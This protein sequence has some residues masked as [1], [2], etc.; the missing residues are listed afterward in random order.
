MVYTQLQLREVFHLEFLRWLGRKVKMNCYALKGGVNL[1]F[2]FH[3]KRYSEDMDLD[4]RS[5]E[6]EALKDKVIGIFSSPT[7]QNNLKSIGIENII[8]P[9]ITK[10]KQ[11]QTTQRFK[12]HL[13]SRAGEEL[14]TKI[15]F[16]RRRL[17]RG[18][19]VETVSNNI[20]RQYRLPPVLVPHYDIYSMAVQKIRA[21]AL[22]RVIQAR[23][24]FDLYILSSQYRLPENKEYCQI[25][26]KEFSLACENLFEVGFDLFHNTVISY[27]AEEEISL[28][29]NPSLWDEI[30]L[31]VY[32]FIKELEGNYA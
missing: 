1:R 7:F 8:L 15:E 23:D 27:L 16:S 2:F 25:S 29:D 28:Y 5:I 10:A 6:V 22:R 13:L 26:K 19:V 32:D 30:K 9:D 31:K 17:E 14:F 24:I 11:T 4:I 18:A 12:V 21:L 20:L 3:S